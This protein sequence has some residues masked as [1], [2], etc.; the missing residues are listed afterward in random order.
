MVL[1]RLTHKMFLGR[2]THK[3]APQSYK[4]VV[5]APTDNTWT[6]NVLWNA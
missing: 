5:I 2:I 1:G 6:T 4:N 3:M